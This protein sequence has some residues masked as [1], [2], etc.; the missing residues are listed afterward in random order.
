M[1]EK[2]TERL[3]KFIDD[4]A[5]GVSLAMTTIAFVSV[6]IVDFRF[7]FKVGE[8]IACDKLADAITSM[9]A[10]GYAKFFNPADGVQLNYANAAKLWLDSKVQ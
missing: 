10:E 5:F 2:K 4:H 6:S 9:E 3:K 7:G 1:K 8:N